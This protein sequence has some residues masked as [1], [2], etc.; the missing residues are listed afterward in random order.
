[1]R[2][3][4]FA[5]V[6]ATGLVVLLLG[7]TSHAGPVVIEEAPA[8]LPTPVLSTAPAP[9]AQVISRKGRPHRATLASRRGRIISRIVS[10]AHGMLGVPYVFGGTSAYGVD[11]SG[12]TMRIFGRAGVPLR[13]MADEQYYQGRKVRNPETGD[14]VFFS[15]YLSGPSHVGIYLGGGRF[16]HASSSRGVMI[17]TLG[18]SYW[19]PRYIGARRFF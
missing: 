15:T 9:R 3:L 13:R 17:N 14:L 6:L 8:P 1:M 4:P 5:P 7:S 10:M 19:G 12:F 2:F 16:I 18:D 11:C